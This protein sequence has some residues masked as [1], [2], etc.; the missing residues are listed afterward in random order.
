MLYLLLQFLSVQL[1]MFE[2]SE[3]LLVSQ[4]CPLFLKVGNFQ[5]CLKFTAMLL[6]GS[7]QAVVTVG[8]EPEDTVD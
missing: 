1:A 2:L 8:V 7:L 4:R 3:S 6:T 5:L